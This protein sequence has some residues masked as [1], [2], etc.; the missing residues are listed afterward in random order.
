[1]KLQK[2]TSKEPAR[3]FFRY[4]YITDLSITYEGFGGEVQLHTPDISSKG[5]FIHTTMS[6]P[7]GAVIRVKFR[8]RQTNYWVI[9]RS[10]VRYSLPGV[11]VGV[12][13]IDISPEAQKAIDN[14]LGI[15]MPPSPDGR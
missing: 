2:Q 1:M 7:E 13:F 14:E 15:E 9:A 11:G 8:L 5:M 12:E 4:K 10:E 6:L 3:S